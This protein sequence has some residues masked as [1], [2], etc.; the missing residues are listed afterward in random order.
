MIKKAQ[1]IIDL[2]RKGQRLRNPELLKQATA[3]APFIL[4]IKGALLAFGV[5]LEFITDAHA[6]A[7]AEI[8]A[9][10]YAVFIGGATVATTRKIG[11]P[12]MKPFTLL[13]EMQHALTHTNVQAFL[14]MISYAEGTDD[15]NGYRAEFGHRK[16][17]PKLFDSYADKPREI[18]RLNGYNSSAKGRYQIINKTWDWIQSVLHLPDFTPPSQDIAAVFLIH[19]R[20]ALDDVIAGRFETAVHKCRNEWASLPGSEH[21]QPTRALNRVKS[22]YTQQGGVIST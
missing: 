14:H 7:L 3:V 1:A 12:G 20:H 18:I 13:G 11:L 8:F 9:T 19:K 4:A 15:E 5:N 16:N 2:F 10:A 6:M 22:Q 17:S 21:G